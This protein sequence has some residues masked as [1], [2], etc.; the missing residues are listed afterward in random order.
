MF[1]EPLD[2]VLLGLLG[3]S[4]WG[5]GAQA[6]DYCVRA[7]L[8]TAWDA[9]EVA[10]TAQ[11]PAAVPELDADSE[12]ECVPAPVRVRVHVPAAAGVGG[13]VGE[14]GC[15]DCHSRRRASSMLQC[16]ACVRWFHRV[17]GGA[18]SQVP[19]GGWICGRCDVTMT[20]SL[21]GSPLHTHRRQRREGPWR[22]R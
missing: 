8:V 22:S 12:L 3:D 1:D 17:C 9:R 2:T 4:Y 19:D 10:V 11:G 6:V 13:H 20:A 15:A 14:R 18:A 5:A 7:F 21:G 16:Q